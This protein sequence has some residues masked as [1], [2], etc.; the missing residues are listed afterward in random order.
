MFKA[1]VV[2]VVV[3]GWDTGAKAEVESRTKN[4]PV[5]I[6]TTKMNKTDGEKKIARVILIEF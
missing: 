1:L 2:V 5:A 3:V 4:I 6:M